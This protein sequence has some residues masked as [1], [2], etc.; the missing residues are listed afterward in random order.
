[1][2]QGLFFDLDGTLVNTYQAD[3]FAYR[4]AI[5]EVAGVEVSAEDFAKTHGQHVRDKLKFLTPE[6][7]EAKVADVSR[8][9]KVYYKKYLYLTEPNS[10]LIK[11]LATCTEHHAI[12]L[13]TTAKKDNALSVLRHHNL[14]RLFTDYVF[15]D[16]VTHPK[17][18]PESYQKAL[19]LSGLKP[20][21]V[22]AFEDSPSGIEAAEAA[23][24]AVIH[25]REFA[26]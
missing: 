24:I 20:E 17:P 11:F 15:G 25:I 18:H 14:E 19:Q 10:T 12:V 16:E 6:L 1:M 23:G 3:F 7:D 26:S 21:Q 2:I 9:K 4:D 8:A 5:Q 22:I 13:V